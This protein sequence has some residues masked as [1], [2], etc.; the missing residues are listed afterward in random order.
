MGLT[1]HFKTIWP[2]FFVGY[3]GYMGYVTGAHPR[4]VGF[5]ADLNHQ[6]PWIQG[7]SVRIQQHPQIIWS[8]SSGRGLHINRSNMI[9]SKSPGSRFGVYYILSWMIRAKTHLNDENKKAALNKLELAIIAGNVG[10]RSHICSMSGIFKKK[11]Q[12]TFGP[13][14][15]PLGIIIGCSGGIQGSKQFRVGPWI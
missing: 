9:Q 2:S 14:L 12:T 10:N 15:Q 3:V 8:T 13:S 7:W 6:Q 5:W 4:V 1:N 11:K